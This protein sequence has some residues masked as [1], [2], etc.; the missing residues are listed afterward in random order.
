MLVQ[1]S[2]TAIAISNTRRCPS[3]TTSDSCVLLP[4]ARTT[5]HATGDE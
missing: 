2:S 3:A 5:N 1:C 4:F